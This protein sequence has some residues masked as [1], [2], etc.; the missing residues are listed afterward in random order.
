MR[1]ITPR[2]MTGLNIKKE[3]DYSGASF[4]IKG[5]EVLEKKKKSYKL[6]YRD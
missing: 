6:L 5:I 3:E 4:D 2:R 1:K